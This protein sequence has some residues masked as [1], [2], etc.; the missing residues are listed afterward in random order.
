MDFDTAALGPFLWQS[1]LLIG[2]AYLLNATLFRKCPAQRRSTLIV[3]LL[4]M[5]LLWISA[6]VHLEAPAWLAPAD[7][8]P[9][10]EQEIT[11]PLSLGPGISHASLQW[12][13]PGE[14]ISEQA[15]A[16]AGTDRS[17]GFD[18]DGALVMVWLAGAVIFLGFYAVQVVLTRH[19][20][21]SAQPVPAG[22]IRDRFEMLVRSL[23]ASR[24]LRLLE[25]SDLAGPAAAGVLCPAVVVPL[26]RAGGTTGCTDQSMIHEILHHKNGDPLIRHGAAI[27]RGIL[28]FQ[29]LIHLLHR[30]IVIEAE[31]VVDL[32]VVAASG[33]REAYI[34]QLHATA[35]R[36]AGLPVRKVRTAA[37]FGDRASLIRRRIEMMMNQSNFETARRPILFGA[38]TAVFLGACALF[39]VV[40][41]CAGPEREA[42][43]SAAA[44]EWVDCTIVVGRDSEGR[45]R[46]RDGFADLSR[47]ALLPS[48]MKNKEFREEQM[49][50]LVPDRDWT[51]DQ[52]EQAL[53]L[54]APV[55]LKS[56]LIFAFGRRDVPWILSAADPTTR[57][58][59]E[60]VPHTVVIAVNGRESRLGED[61]DVDH[62]RGFIRFLNEED[63]TPDTEYEVSYG[64][65]PDPDRPEFVAGLAF[66]RKGNDTAAKGRERVER[67][68]SSPIEKAGL[69]DLHDLYKAVKPEADPIGL[70]KTG[71]AAVFFPKRPLLDRDFK[72]MLKERG[73][74]GKGRFLVNREEYTFD[75]STQRI[76]LSTGVE[77]DLARQSLTAWGVPED[78]RTYQ[79][80][81]AI[82]KDS[83]RYT[84][85][86]E[87][88]LV[89]YERNRVSLLNREFGKIEMKPGMVLNTVFRHV[90]VAGDWT[91]RNF[92]EGMSR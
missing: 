10:G 20:L 33:G 56:E 59:V 3:V 9:L 27:V 68:G 67:A 18:M 78:N 57:R 58:V 53:T 82:G 47:V 15:T 13:V 61:Y 86:G 89:D 6:A 77:F 76:I 28:W 19:F 85:E 62:K 72:L 8:V 50:T 52:E 83:V 25:S 63:C 79:F 37:L 22:P 16:A 70:W 55:D 12:N 30:S 81:G 14:W 24:R 1:S 44:A 64:Y 90:V 34:D 23:G 36:A 2:L 91:I 84:Y 65:C 75:P 48:G 35:R 26:D 54:A 38:A 4:L 92:P 7:A 80:P 31:R 41:S 66:C 88:F 32:A 73:A 29:P 51:F 21:S 49:K 45:Y 60:I 5:P 87:G 69:L 42:Q 39:L 17:A 71:D 43:S 11:A 46:L 40:G 74:Q